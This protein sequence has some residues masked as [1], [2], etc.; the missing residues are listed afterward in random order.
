MCTYISNS[1]EPASSSG[2]QAP[3]ANSGYQAPA[4]SSAY[5]TPAPSSGYQAPA[6]SSGFQSQAPNSGY[7]SPAPNN[8]GFQSPA[9]SSGFQSTQSN[10]G[11]QSSQPSSNFNS[12]F[13][14]AAPSFSSTSNPFLAPVKNNFDESAPVVGDVSLL[15]KINTGNTFGSV[16]PLPVFETAYPQSQT[17]NPQ[18]FASS[19][20]SSTFSNVGQSQSGG[21]TFQ[22]NF[23]TPNSNLGIPPSGFPSSNNQQSDSYGSP[24]GPIIGNQNSQFSSNSGF[25]SFN[26]QPLSTP[27]LN[28]QIVGAG[29]SG[30]IDSYGSPIGPAISGQNSV[31]TNQ[32]VSAPSGYGGPSQQG[33]NPAPL[34]NQIVAP[35]SGYGVP[36]APVLSS[37]ALP[38]PLIQQPVSV[39]GTQPGSVVAS[40][41][42]QVAVAPQSGYGSPVGP[43]I[44]EQILNS[45]PFLSNSFASQPVETSY[46][47]SS[48]S[49][50]EQ[51]L[52]E[53]KPSLGAFIGSLD[54]DS[55][56][57]ELDTFSQNDQF[58]SSGD[59]YSQNNNDQFSSNVDVDTFP[60]NNND[61]YSSSVGPSSPKP[62]VSLASTFLHVQAGNNGESETKLTK[63]SF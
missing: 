29:N 50:S 16:N 27:V 25:S 34:N 6:P 62:T 60:P 12:G 4:P 9:S 17:F 11:Y 35:S 1:R 14:T 18:S 56:N 59:T 41:I 47:F 53:V 32:G 31:F 61:Q 26:N 49:D 38:N 52:P 5:Q 42:P 39:Y 7:Q 28:G 58:S 37:P 22:G 3:Q 8:S 2:Y 46:G 45:S 51:K 44:G 63:I 23:Q 30:S 48:G 57:L 54:Q 43:I 24:T 36:S 10:S 55:G 40:P 20:P 19:S 15:T 33:F 13:Q 21:T